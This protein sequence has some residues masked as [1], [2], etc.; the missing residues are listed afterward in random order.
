ML[1]GSVNWK[2]RYIHNLLPICKIKCKTILK[3][4]GK[5]LGYTGIYDIP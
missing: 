4:I 5:K 2:D 1:T 3:P